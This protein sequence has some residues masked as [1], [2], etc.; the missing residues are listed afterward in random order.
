MISSLVSNYIFPCILL[1]PP[2]YYIITTLVSYYIPL[3]SYY[4]H[5]CILLY[6]PCILLYPPLYLII[7]PLVSYYIP[8]AVSLGPL[9]PIISQRQFPWGNFPSD[10][11]LSGYFPKVQFPGRSQMYIF[12]NE[13]FP[14]GNFT[15]KEKRNFP[16]EGSIK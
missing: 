6:P 9:Y 3:V 15:I 16:H 4:N 1:Y 10:N 12:L 5:P 7:Y 2:L 11:F 13:N 8:K 14:S